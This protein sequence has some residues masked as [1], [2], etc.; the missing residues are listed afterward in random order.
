MIICLCSMG[1]GDKRHAWNFGGIFVREGS[2]IIQG[3]S[4]MTGTDLCVNKCK[5]SRLYLNH[6][7]I[8]IFVFGKL[9]MKM[10]KWHKWQ[11]TVLEVLGLSKPGNCVHQICKWRAV[12]DLT[13]A[14]CQDWLKLWQSLWRHCRNRVRLQR[15]WPVTTVHITASTY[16]QLVHCH[17]GVGLWLLDCWNHGFE[18]RCI[19]GRSSLVSCKKWSLQCVYHCFRGVILDMF[20]YW[21]WS[22]SLKKCC[23]LVR[24]LGRGQ[25]Q[26]VMLIW[27]DN[28]KY[29]L[30]EQVV[31]MVSLVKTVLLLGRHFWPYKLNTV[32]KLCKLVPVSTTLCNLFNFQFVLLAVSRFT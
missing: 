2:G 13:S 25:R 6:L 19:H 26:I 17:S 29:I 21:V 12:M 16:R 28:V 18:S 20:V 23:G 32:F 27:R 5:Q 1:G 8:Q 14:H 22:R 30:E 10:W 24:D 15:R 9:I 31:M 7:V 11:M 3:G 4:N